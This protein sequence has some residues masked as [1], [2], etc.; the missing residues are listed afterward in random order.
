MSDRERLTRLDL[1]VQLRV[2]PRAAKREGRHCW[3]DIEIT[4]I[5]KSEGPAQVAAH[6]QLGAYH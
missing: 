1:A 5:R 4:P 2:R 3:Q 6:L